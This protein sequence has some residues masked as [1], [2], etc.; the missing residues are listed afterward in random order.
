MLYNVQDVANNIILQTD[1]ERGDAI[2]NLKLQKLLYYLQGY[3][4]A[5]FGEPFFDNN[6]EAW[7]YGPVVPDVYHRFK[8]N[9]HLA[10]ELDEQEFKRIDFKPKVQDMFDQVMREYGK[11]SAIK[12]MEMTHN[13]KPW[14]E[15]FQKPDKLISNKT[16]ESFFKLMIE[17]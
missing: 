11:F 15:A 12:L 13:E 14:K 8:E 10:I 9:K 4:L 2:T 3:H 17:E 5:F 6:I 1:T 16:L 7:T